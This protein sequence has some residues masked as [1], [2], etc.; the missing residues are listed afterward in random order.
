MLAKSITL[1]GHMHDRTQFRRYFPL[2]LYQNRG[3]GAVA[4]GRLAASFGCR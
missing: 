2:L 4:V 3:C 1:G